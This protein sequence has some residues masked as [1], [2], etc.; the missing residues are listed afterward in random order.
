MPFH[1]YQQPNW[2]LAGPITPASAVPTPLANGI[3]YFFFNVTNGGSGPTAAP[4]GA[5]VPSG[6]NARTFMVA[7]GEDATSSSVNRGMKALL[8]NTDI[9][10]NILNTD[11]VR[12]AVFSVAL[13][14]DS[15]SFNAP[16]GLYLGPVGSP[17]SPSNLRELIRICDVGGQ[18][19]YSINDEQVVLA[20]SCSLPVSPG[21]ADGTEVLT[22]NSEIP[23]GTYL[24][25][26]YASTSY[27]RATVDLLRYPL[28]ASMPVLPGSV[29]LTLSSW[30]G[31]GDPWD[32]PGLPASL[33]GL[34]TRMLHGV[35]SGS[36]DQISRPLALDDYYPG[37]TTEQPGSGATYSRLGPSMLGYSQQNLSTAPSSGTPWFKDPMGGIWTAYCNDTNTNKAFSFL[38]LV[39]FTRG[40]V[41][42]GHRTLS[43]NNGANAAKAPALASFASYYEHTFDFSL[44]SQ[45]PTYLQLP[46]SCILQR[47]LG[48][49]RV[50][51]SGSNRFTGVV[52]GFTRTSLIAGYTLVEIEWTRTGTPAD[53]TAVGP[54][55]RIYRIQAI[56]NANRIRVMALDGGVAELP[57]A[58]TFG[59]I[60][61]VLSPT[62]VTPE[63]VAE[64]RRHYGSA[65]AD[66]M[67][68]GP[69]EVLQPPLA[70]YRSGD[71]VVPGAA[72]FGATLFSSS[73]A[74]LRWGG[75]ENRQGQPDFG[76][77]RRVGALR[78]DGSIRTTMVE[79][80]NLTSPLATIASGTID[81]LQSLEGY[82]GEL[83]APFAFGDLAQFTAGTFSLLT[84]GR[85]VHDTDVFSASG[86]ITFT[87]ELSALLNSH[88]VVRISISAAYAIFATIAVGT[89]TVGEE[90]ELVF[91]HTL[92][93]GQVSNP[94]T[95]WPSNFKFSSFAD[96]LLSQKLGWID[97]YTCKVISSSV[98]Q[99]SLSRS[100]P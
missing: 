68:A 63:G 29:G 11:R 32:T 92:G 56:D 67:E 91:D 44:K 82:I 47:V 58:A 30:R 73:Y 49:D 88:K 94:A 77:Y 54:T 3:S 12:P 62:F 93:L 53:P 61:R 99:V 75:F 33:Y 19:L 34:R 31:D 39:G 40:F 13:D 89:R 78:G 36:Q 24:V 96:R 1:R 2:Y 22:F 7:L 66:L 60:T 23:A 20:Q 48:E 80:D 70:T 95:S 5:Q 84:A 28:M 76:W 27:T 97:R 74:A 9:I 51:V 81:N 87:T 8:E 71:Q 64:L 43:T 52:S 26:G 14:S 72:Y 85:Q 42:V 65:N 4:V 25:L 98:I 15:N 46:A 21:Y 50:E 57:A 83:E 86:T 90:F 55:K 35:Y 69:L 41:F 37:A 38:S 79:T 100:A 17:T 18:E 6:P 10:D 59:T 45:A 16:E